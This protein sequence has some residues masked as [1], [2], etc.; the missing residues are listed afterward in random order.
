MCLINVDVVQGAWN[1]RINVRVHVQ[2]K[3]KGGP[4][5]PHWRPRPLSRE[6]KAAAGVG[7]LGADD[8]AWLARGGA[9]G[10]HVMPRSKE[11][12]L[13]DLSG[14]IPSAGGCQE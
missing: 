10:S 11:S 3:N 8:E 7:V 6:A 5:R 14:S 13:D 9:G 2:S 12:S 4:W 1:V